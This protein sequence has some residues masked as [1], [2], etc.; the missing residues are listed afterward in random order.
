MHK[1]IQLRCSIEVSLREKE[2]S[3]NSVIAYEVNR[4]FVFAKSLQMATHGTLNTLSVLKDLAG[5][6]KT[7]KQVIGWQLSNDL[8]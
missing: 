7:L 2:T 5:K 3:L 8:T 4:S 1:I 6:L